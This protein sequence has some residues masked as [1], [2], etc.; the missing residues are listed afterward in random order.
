V[1]HLK[2]FFSD[3]VGIEFQAWGIYHYIPIFLVIF[4]VC[5]IFLFRKKIRA[6]GKDKTIRYILG[7]IGIVSEIS[8]QLWILLNGNYTLRDNL[9]IG[10]CAFSLFMG[11]YVMFTKSYKVFEVAYFWAIGGVVSVLFPDILF[12]PDRFRYYQFLFGHMIFFFMF[13][14]MLFVNQYIPTWKSFRKS[15]FILL[16]IVVVIIIPINNLFQ[17]N[18]MYLLEPGDTPFSLFWGNGYF[19]YLVGCISLSIVVMFVWFSPIAIYLKL[20]KK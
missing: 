7:S 18:F 8:L 17:A 5:L 11:I 16:F 2:A 15:F 10:L 14:Y 20:Q 12:G 13:M 6:S 4:G 1:I 3:S 9:P 19:L